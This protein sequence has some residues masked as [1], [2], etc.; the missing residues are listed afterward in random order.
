MSYVVA[1]LAH[2]DGNRN[3][4]GYL[5]PTRYRY[6]YGRVRRL[7]RPGGESYNEPFGIRSE[8]AIL[9]ALEFAGGKFAV[10]VAIGRT[11]SGMQA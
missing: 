1:T 7:E 9:K 11:K 4:A 2:V 3:A 5:P 6:H 10:A 8:S